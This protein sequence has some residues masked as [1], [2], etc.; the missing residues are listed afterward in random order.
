MVEISMKRPYPT[1]PAD[2]TPSLSK[3]AVKSSAGKNEQV[4]LVIYPHL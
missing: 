4:P 3:E 2:Q 1:S